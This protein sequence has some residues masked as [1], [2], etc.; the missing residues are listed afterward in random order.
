LYFPQV[1]S[2]QTPIAG[3]DTQS[4][5][6]HGG[7]AGTRS[8]LAGPFRFPCERFEPPPSSR[9]L[10][11]TYTVSPEGVLLVSDQ[12]NGG[13]GFHH[14]LLRHHGN[15]VRPPQRPE[16]SPEPTFLGWHAREVFKGAARHIA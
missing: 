2:P 10:A 4:H 5:R 6:V 9:P 12:A 14:T 16:W 15:Q 11:G 3:T 8:P 7:P 13:E 1:R